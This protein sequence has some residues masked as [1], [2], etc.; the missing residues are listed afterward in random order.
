MER[1]GFVVD[2]AAPQLVLTVSAF[3]G[4]LPVGVD[5]VVLD[6]LD[7]GGFSGGRVSDGDRVAPLRSGN[8]AYVMFTSGSTGRPKGVSVS[9]GAIVNQLAWLAGEYGVGADDRVMARAPFTF[10]VSVWESFL[11]IGR[12]SCRE[13]VL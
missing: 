10:D 9:H 7:V 1:I 4:V 8:A 5:V 6:G 13:R 3:V 2:S 11:Q 12:A